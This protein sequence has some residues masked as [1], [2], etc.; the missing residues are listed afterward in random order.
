MSRSASECLAF[1]LPYHFISFG[2]QTRA[3]KTPIDGP[4]ALAVDHA[5][6]L[7]VASLYEKNVRRIDLRTGLIE[8]V[9]GNGKECCYRENAKATDV[10]LDYIWAI[11]VN[12]A[13]D[14]VRH[15]QTKES[16]TDRLHLNHRVTPRLHTCM[17]GCVSDVKSPLL[18][19]PSNRAPLGPYEITAAIGAGGMVEAWKAR[20]QFG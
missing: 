4:A 9:A 14:L 16:A 11:A 3:T 5:G 12:S 6:H 1:W 8:T 20:C 10:G 7:F 15:R 19:A 2:Q 13:G 17:D 18:Y